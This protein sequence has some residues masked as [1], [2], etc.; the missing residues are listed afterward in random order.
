LEVIFTQK[1]LPA[2]DLADDPDDV[3][4]VAVVLGEDERLGD[5]PAPGED[6]VLVVRQEQ[7]VLEV[8]MT[9]RIWSDET[10]RRSSSRAS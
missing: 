4:G 6:A 2:E 3:L 10:T 5:D 8:G 7:V 9:V 1:S